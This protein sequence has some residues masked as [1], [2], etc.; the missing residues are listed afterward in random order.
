MSATGLPERSVIGSD[1]T[2]GT[3]IRSRV[4]MISSSSPSAC[5]TSSATSVP[6]G[7]RMTATA[8]SRLQPSVD[9]PSTSRI[10]SPAR[11]PD[12]WAGEL[13][14]GRTITIAP[15]TELTVAPMPSKE[16]PD[17][18][19]GEAIA[20]GINEDGVFVFQGVDDAIDRG[21]ASVE[22]F[23]LGG[24]DEVFVQHLD[25]FVEDSES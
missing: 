23:K 21:C 20:F 9:S 11:M 25:D 17:V 22:R 8:C 10:T 16:P 13:R 6:L 4:T 19:T 1:S 2:L 18:F 12:C 15:S 5:R 24:I 7:P 3:T 14:K